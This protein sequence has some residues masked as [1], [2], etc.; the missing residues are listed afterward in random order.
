[1]AG[2]QRGQVDPVQ[3]KAEIAAECLK[4]ARQELSS[5]SGPQFDKC[6]MG[7]QYFAHMG[8][9]DALTVLERHAS[10]ALAQHLTAAKST[11]QQHFDSAKQLLEKLDSPAQAGRDTLGLNR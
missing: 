3:I 2:G 9:V 7:S 8:M 10:P 6:Y 11:A 4:S 5:K 1:V